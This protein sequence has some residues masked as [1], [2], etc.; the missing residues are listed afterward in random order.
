MRCAMRKPQ[1]IQFK[2]FVAQ[3]TQLNNYL[4]LFPV[5]GAVKR[6]DPEELND[7]L[8][9]AVPNPWSRQA[10]IQGWDFKGWSFKE[11]WNIFE[12]MYI[13]GS[14]YKGGAPSKNAQQVEAYCASYG[15]KKKWGTSASP[16]NPDQGRSGKRKRSNADHMSNEPTGAKKICLMR[17]FWHAL[18]SS[19]ELVKWW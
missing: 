8:L 14:I 3:L 9:L 16:S 4:P 10:Y 11:A 12:R 2:I 1:D 6:M 17:G 18:C 13:T 7:I 15:R 19:V 5:L